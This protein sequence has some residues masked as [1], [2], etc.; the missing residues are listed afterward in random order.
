[1]W[2][3]CTMKFLAGILVALLALPALGEVL[4]IV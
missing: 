4:P 2:D 3:I 1:M